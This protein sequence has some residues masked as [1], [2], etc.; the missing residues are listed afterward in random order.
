ME[1]DNKEADDRPDTMAKKRTKKRSGVATKPSSKRAVGRRQRPAQAADA[2]G[3]HLVIVESPTKAKTINKYLGP[4]YVVMASVGHVRDL[5]T[6]NPKGVTNP[7]PGVDLDQ[8]FTPT[9]EILPNSRQTISQLKRVAKQAEDVW[10]ATDL[11]R[12]GEAIAWHLAQALGVPDGTAKRVV[13]NAITQKEIKY[14]FSNPR[15]IDPN[16]VN[17]Q[18][19]RRILD[20]IVGYQVSP[21][22]WKKVAGGLSAG[23][24][25]SVATRLV[26]DRE[27]KIEAFIPEESWKISGYFT[28][29]STRQATYTKQW[30]QFL[31]SEADTQRTIR[32]KTVWLNEHGCI[33]AELV[34]L[35]G[36][37]FKPETR[38][39]ALVAAQ[40]VGFTLDKET[41]WTDENAKGPAR[42]RCR[43]AGHVTNQGDA[44]EFQITSI[45]TKRTNSR[46]LAP[47][48]T[49]TLQQSA[50]I[51]LGFKLQRT[52]RT[53]QQLYEGI[54]IHGI[55][56]Q[57]G[58]ITYM[59]TDSTH[60]SDEAIESARTFINDEY[61]NDY[62]PEK[63]N[64][65]T[66]SNKSAQEAHEAI[67]PTDVRITP[68]RLQHDLTED[69]YKL[70]KMIWERFVAC[71]MPPAQWDATTVNIHCGPARFRANGRV[72]VFDGFYRVSGQP[73]S[74]SEAILPQLQQDQRISPI[75]IDP[76]QHFSSPPARYTEASLQKKL[77][78][79]GI[80][81]PSTYAS[82]IQTIQDRKYV[83][84]VVPRD[85]RL[86]ATD[87]GKVVTD[88]LVDAF[89]KIMDVGYTKYME[90]ELDKVEVERHDWVEMLH[91][92]YGPFRDNLDKAH[93]QMAHAK[94][95]S[96][97]AP[98]ICPKCG[99]ST[100]YR[101][102]RNGRFL[103][104][105]AYHVPPKP[106]KIAQHPDQKFLLYKAKGKARPKVI[107]K[108]G[109]TRVGWTKLT[110]EQKQ[111]FQKISD[112]M[113][114][115]C[116]FA[117]PVD[118]AGNPVQPEVTDVICPEDQL[119]MIKRKGR[120]GPFLASQSYP[121]VRY[122]LKLDPKTHT[123]VLPKV[124]PLTT[125]E[126][127]SKC[128]A[129]LN[130]RDSKRGFWLS[131]STFPKCRGRGRWADV[132]DDKRQALEQ[133]WHQHCKTNQ[134]PKI[135][136]SEG[137]IIEEGYAPQIMA[138]DG[139]R[140]GNISL[141]TASSDAA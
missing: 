19:A 44:A 86:Y 24:V 80:G 40:A 133:A 43:Y 135:T 109:N 72:L 27:R 82:I 46:P 10:F 103:S 49:S 31:D 6:R 2:T 128:E 70:Y 120:F 55:E 75:Q 58:L 59:R 101:F 51:G 76:T 36:K 17:A 45:Q 64:T 26:V 18:Q 33:R 85:K 131:C 116:E 28:P 94:A 14:A 71:Q 68:K 134:P 121:K 56:G 66:S 41:A 29:D 87:L 42:E 60:L 89:P 132:A 3:K 98:H 8:D 47:F 25:Q 9:Y 105:T 78:E 48:I 84:T 123:V 99:S 77:E 13:F 74:G 57:T 20:R 126:P 114:P 117:A 5:P 100:E 81:R 1:G 63:P 110:P 62:L 11:D 112:Q 52:M 104:C 38:E 115:S 37:S 7:V 91:A 95:E 119:P 138:E 106:I 136:N 15:Q 73:N 140:S 88:K 67:R 30:A 50:A 122:I 90:D 124:P 21:L 137:K 107:S 130:L 118:Q 83:D 93:K 35:K 4:N 53:A 79:E 92:F 39:K 32:E 129:P 34:E 113:P 139:S 96:L 125:D 69:Q 65:Y 23:R 16:R 22:L 108:D 102:G 141:D 97:P 12:E 54:D 61:G 127:C 111:K